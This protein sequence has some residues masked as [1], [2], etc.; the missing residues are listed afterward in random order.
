MLEACLEAVG[1]RRLLWGSDMTMETGWAKLR[2]LAHLLSPADL[3]L[4][5][6]KNAAQIFP[7]TSFPTG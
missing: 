5:K 4:V 2:Y 3:E 6:W 7:A 1:V